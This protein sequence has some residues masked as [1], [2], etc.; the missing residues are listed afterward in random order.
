MVTK[1][2]FFPSIGNVVE[3]TAGTNDAIVTDAAAND[4]DE[5]NAVKE[6][7]S[8]CMNCGENV[9]CDIMQHFCRHCVLTLSREQPDCY[10]HLFHTSG[11]S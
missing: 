4:V 1:E 11:K 3:K 8:L 6:I 2:E 9:R 10:W 7:E 5:E